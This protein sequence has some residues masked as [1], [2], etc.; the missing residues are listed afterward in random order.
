MVWGVR[1]RTTVLATA[2]VLVMLVLTGAALV[3]SQRHTLTDTVDEVLQRESA[4]IADD[5]DTGTM[6]E[7]IEGQGD[8]DAFA[9]VIGPSGDIVA[10]TT[11]APGRLDVP[12]PDEGRTTFRSAEVPGGEGEYRVMSSW[13]DDV[14]IGRA[15]CRERV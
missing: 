2:L 6:P 14:E 5:V 13:H 8:D 3:A 1:A 9:Q 4:T 12:L 7:V 15:S 10:A 11:N